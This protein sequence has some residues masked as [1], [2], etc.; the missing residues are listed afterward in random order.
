MH[1]PEN[2]PSIDDLAVLAKEKLPTITTTAESKSVDTVM[3][4]NLKQ[5]NSRNIPD[6]VSTQLMKITTAAFLGVE[7][8]GQTS[9]GTSCLRGELAGRSRIYVLYTAKE[10]LAGFSTVRAVEPGST[11]ANIT[12]TVIAP[13]YQGKGVVGHLMQEIEKNL[14][15]TGYRTLIREARTDNGWASTLHRHYGERIIATF[16]G[17]TDKN[18]PRIGLRIKLV[19]PNNTRPSE[20][21]ISSSS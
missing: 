20:Q 9:L 8:L 5:Y 7:Q 1:Q 13:D 12:L 4:F 11:E 2:G 15:E 19:D 18:P 16:T 17:E 21:V 14:W 6:P 10:E 3:V